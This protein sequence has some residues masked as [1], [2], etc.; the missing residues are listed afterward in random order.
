[1]S[2][3]LVVVGGLTGSGKSAVASEI[4]IAL[5]AIGVRTVWEEGDIERGAVS[6]DRLDPGAI[7]DLKVTIREI[8][9]PRIPHG[10]FGDSTL[11]SSK[12][13]D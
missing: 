4:D 5:R 1:M 8:N 11:G 6:P 3:V 13:P 12:A 10:Y 9:T 7:A 2:E